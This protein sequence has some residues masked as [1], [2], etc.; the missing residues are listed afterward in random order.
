MRK[1]I[2]ISVVLALLSVAAFA[3][4]SVGGSLGA[5]VT[6]IQGTSADSEALTG[7]IEFK[8][9][10][11]EVN[12]SNSDGTAGGRLRVSASASPGWWGG[13]SFAFGWWKPIPQLRLQIGHNADG[14]FGAAQITGWG[15]NAEAQDF[16]AIDQDSGDSGGNGW[17]AARRAG[18]YGG[19]SDVGVTLS[20]FPIDGLTINLVVPFGNGHSES[21][22][23]KPVGETYSRF[24]LNVV[25]AL[26]D[27][28]ALRV[29]F[30]GLGGLDEDMEKSAPAGN[31]FASFYLTA[32]EGLGI[33]LGA[34]LGVPYKDASDTNINP[35]GVQLGLGLRYVAG[36]F[37]IKAR[38]G[39]QLQRT[40][41]S[42]AKQ[43]TTI[44]LV[45]LPYYNFSNGLT[46][47]LNAGFGISIPE[48]DADQT[49]DWLI[50]PYIRK[51]VSAFNFYAG[52]KLWSDGGVDPET[53]W[54][55]PIGFN[56]YF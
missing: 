4:P 38:F 56:A 40:T 7:G 22:N 33:D 14:D 25:F 12:Y 17:K 30:Q 51:A 55:I 15:F 49:V 46:G 45:F 35:Y 16:V 54:A 23:G 29:S 32:I 36:D 43:D 11:V 5:K 21:G 48:G 41:N 26:P 52:F 27:V 34:G 9:Q 28:G 3:Q 47:Y 44:G 19:Y 37:G 31:F 18:F 6:L 8:N 2:V 10:R 53:K 13:T 50:N 20:V 42:G 24:H 39:T 1:L